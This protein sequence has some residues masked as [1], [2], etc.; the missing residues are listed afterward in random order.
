MRRNVNFD[1]YSINRNFLINPLPPGGPYLFAALLRGLIREERL[2]K[3]EEY[4]YFNTVTKGKKTS[5][6]TELCT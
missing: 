3:G 1:L 6:T 5:N 2:D 4:Y